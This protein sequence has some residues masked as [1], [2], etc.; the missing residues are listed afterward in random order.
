MSRLPLSQATASDLFGANRSLELPLFG[1][2]VTPPLSERALETP[3][4]ILRRVQEQGRGAHMSRASVEERVQP[5][6]LFI[7][8]D[9]RRWTHFGL[10]RILAKLAPSIPLAQQIPALIELNLYLLEPHLIVI[11]QL[12][13][14]I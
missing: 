8:L 14:P 3:V 7:S 13:L 11:C 5:G 6:L 9:D 1:G 4:R 10:V 12:A 2:I